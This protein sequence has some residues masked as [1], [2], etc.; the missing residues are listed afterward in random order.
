MYIQQLLAMPAKVGRTL[1]I[2]L[3]QK[4]IS[5]GRVPLARNVTVA[6]RSILNENVG[7]QVTVCTWVNLLTFGKLGIHTILLARLK[8]SLLATYANMHQ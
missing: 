6:A 1:V 4:K 8:R 5:E 7:L 3:T 2:V